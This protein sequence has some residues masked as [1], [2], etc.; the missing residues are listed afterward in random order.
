MRSPRFSI[1][2]ILGHLEAIEIRGEEDAAPNDLLRQPRL[3][4]SGLH[5]STAPTDNGK[6]AR[7]LRDH[8]RL[9]L[10]RLPELFLPDLRDPR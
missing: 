5:Q 7:V 4:R 6:R 2:K 8:R 1:S 3:V 9:A 10:Q